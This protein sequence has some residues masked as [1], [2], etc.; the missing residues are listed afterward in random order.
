MW[1]GAPRSSRM[2]RSAVSVVSNSGGRAKLTLVSGIRTAGAVGLCGN[3]DVA[4]I[5]C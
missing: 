1:G 5:S 3:R 2:I 4:G